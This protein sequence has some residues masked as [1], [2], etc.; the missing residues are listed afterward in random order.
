MKKVFLFAVLM[1]AAV[2]TQAQ[3]DEDYFKHEVAVSYGSVSNST[4][5]G[6]MENVASIT[7][8]FGQATYDNGEFFGPL[9][10]EYFYHLNPVVGVGA[11]AAYASETKNIRIGGKQYYDDKATNSFITVLPA[12]KFN[13]LR[14]KYFGLYSKIGLGASFRSQKQ[15]WTD[16]NQQKSKSESDV[17]FNFQA[18]GLGIEAGSPRIRAFAEIGIGEQGI[19][20]GGLRCKF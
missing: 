4:W 9:A 14:K 2:G 10:V 8:T 15:E 17:F 1:I 6:V 3:N 11:I 18:T 12:V 16:G 5:L 7:A 19:F 20:S 13:W